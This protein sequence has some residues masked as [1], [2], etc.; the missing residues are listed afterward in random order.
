MLSTDSITSC[1]IE[2][3]IIF[4]PF[5]PLK[6]LRSIIAYHSFPSCCF[7]WDAVAEAMHTAK[8][9]VDGLKEKLG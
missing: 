2:I 6:S 9:A 8:Q 1:R 5:V 7:I 3:S 4:H